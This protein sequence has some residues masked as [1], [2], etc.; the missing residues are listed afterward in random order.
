[1]SIL[2]RI[3]STLDNRM[4]AIFGSS[5]RP[6]AKE[7]IELYVDAIDQIVQRA[8]A[9]RRGRL[10]F[11]FDR[12]I[13]ELHAPSG[14]R[15]AVLET[16][17]DAKQMVADIR[18]RVEAPERLSVQVQYPEEAEKELSIRCEKTDPAGQPAPV[19]AVKH[20]LPPM[21]LI[22]L[23]GVS[24]APE[25]LVDRPRVNLGRERDIV[26]PEGRPLRRNELHFPEGADEANA[27]VSRSHAHIRFDAHTGEWRL[28]DDGSSLGTAIF[29]D[30]RRI[31]VPAHAPRG[32]MLLP[33]DEI[34]L[35]RARL[36][37]ATP[38]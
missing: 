29:R 17:F 19:P 15:R 7:A 22:T 27:T 31:D 18:E 9:G 26:D 35:G 25:F 2:R 32:A 3:E 16:V 11:P 21:W 23:A 4:R 37:F 6:G 1:M 20:E 14:E 34:Y 38:R 24:S 10:V 8:A 30:G 12:V 13:V 33:G 28:Y 5:N 36:L